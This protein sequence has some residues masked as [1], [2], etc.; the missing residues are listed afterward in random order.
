MS[1]ASW[2]EHFKANITGYDPVEAQGL[3]ELGFAII[4]QKI[5]EQEYLSW[6]RSAF[7]MQSVDM[8][9]F[10]KTT[11]P[12]ALVS[13]LREVY[14][15]G[16][17]VIPV[18]EWDGHTIILA[19]ELPE[20][21]IPVE[22][23]PILILAPVSQM[24]EFWQTVLP[25]LGASEGEV[26]EIEPP[27]EAL[28]GISLEAAAPV[29]SLD[30]SQLRSPLTKTEPAVQTESAKPE[31]IKIALESLEET[32]V[33]TAIDDSATPVKAIPQVVSVVSAQAGLD[34]TKI[35]RCLSLFKH[36][37]DNRCFV[38][39]S[40]S[41]KSFQATH[42][43]EESNITI[44]PSKFELQS[45]SFIKIVY[46]TQ[47]PYHGHLIKTLINEKFFAELNNGT[48]PEN[49]TAIPIV[50]NGETVGIVMGWG[51]ATNYKQQTLREMENV[52]QNLCAE[53]GFIPVENAA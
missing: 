5:N 28:E 49:V 42:W 4:N 21:P 29:V 17:E 43:P 36:I 53:L 47:K 40:Q 3:T 27:V 15:W 35:L 14:P 41:A 11:P 22:L 19:L 31:P 45:D 16:P 50:H 24:F 48:V 10:Q 12:V 25:Q 26:L 37:Y 38:S 7:E 39:I 13:K 6:A 2:K 23:K 9:F 30:F 52:V 34:Q 8:N 1:T 51:P 33:P 18:A 44:S 46:Q 32:V 20:T